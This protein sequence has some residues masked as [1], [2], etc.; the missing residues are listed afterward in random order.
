[1]KNEKA[2]KKETPRNAK[3]LSALT[4]KLRVRLGTEAVVTGAAELEALGG[5]K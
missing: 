1:M 4:R 3:A 2:A 5:D